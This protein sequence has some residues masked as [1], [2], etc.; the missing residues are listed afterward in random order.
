MGSQ[1]KPRTLFG[2]DGIRGQA[3]IFPMTSEV[4]MQVGAATAQV[5]LKRAGGRPR[6]TYP[7]PR[8]II[9]KDTRVSSYMLEFAIAAGICSQGADVLLV[10]PLPTP[11]VA[12]LVKSMR[13]DAGIMI[14]ASHNAF[15]DNGIKI[16]DHDGFKLPDQL[17]EEI[18]A[19]VLASL[20]RNF[21][22]RAQNAAQAPTHEAIGRAV[23]IDDA[24]GR[25]MEFL[26]GTLP[27]GFSLDGMTVVVDCAHGAAYKVAP[28]L[29]KE[30]GAKV[31]KRGVEP[32]GGNINQRVGAL[33]PEVAAGAVVEFGA[34][35]GISLDGDA[36]R[37]I[38]CDERGERV[39]GDQIMGICA[40]DLQA[41]GRLQ[42]NTVVAT[43]MSN[44]GLEIFLH[45]L[46]IKLERT[47]V[48]DRYVTE[49]MRKHGYNFGGEQSGHIIFHD[50]ASTGDGLLAALRVLEIMRKQG[51]KLSEL[52]REVALLPQVREDIRVRE[53]PEISSIPEAFALIKAAEKSLAGKGR[54]FVRYSGTE[55]LLRVMIEG[56]D[57]IMIRQECKRIAA[58]FAAA[59]GQKT[60]PRERS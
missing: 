11:A 34:Q 24:L 3:N 18:E 10:G 38:L 45:S 15:E 46:G 19:I 37:V 36:D 6:T 42:H 48:G 43:P 17:E 1:A 8:I 27:S 58:A 30:L 23:R 40:R 41:Q 28:M 39:D 56:Q 54:V 25:Y 4:A 50:Y 31:V 20:Q 44:Q 52:K 47:A 13:A 49:S 7:H 26:K 32:S 9:G 14:S 16:F 53:K 60:Q 2:T 21:T 33:F 5:L 55:P 57:P 22:D 29:F 35:L 12:Y 59:I 51:K